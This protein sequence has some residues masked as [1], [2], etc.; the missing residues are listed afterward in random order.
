MK[1]MI[2]W[3]EGHTNTC[4][5]QWEKSAPTYI[6]RQISSLVHKSTWYN[7]TPMDNLWSLP[8]LYYNP[9]G[10]HETLNQ[11]WNPAKSCSVFLSSKLIK[12]IKN[13]CI[14]LHRRQWTPVFLKQCKYLQCKIVMKQNNLT[15]VQWGHCSHSLLYTDNNDA[16][17]GKS[18]AASLIF[19]Y[20]RG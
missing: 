16:F 7:V 12:T 6:C 1:G 4:I 11:F 13:K 18:C 5:D 20:I 10:V 8:I 3:K 19:H 9:F 2:K 17:L 15:I 14:N